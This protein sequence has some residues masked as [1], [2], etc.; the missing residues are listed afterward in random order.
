MPLNRADVR[1]PNATPFLL[2]SVLI[3]GAAGCLVALLAGC[4]SALGG[5]SSPAQPSVVV[6]PQ[7]A[8]I[9]CQDGSQ[10]P[11]R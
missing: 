7:G 6:L 10:P 11:C 2:R 8:K 3:I 5:G 1:N 9:V 4:S